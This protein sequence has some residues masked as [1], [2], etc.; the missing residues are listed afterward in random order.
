MKKVVD[1]LCISCT[2]VLGQEERDV[3]ASVTAVK[4]QR[5]CGN[6]L[7][8]LQTGLLSCKGYH[9]T[10]RKQP[11]VPAEKVKKLEEQIRQ[12]EAGDFGQDE[13]ALVFSAPF[14]GEQ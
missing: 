8:G 1:L 9:R 4:T 5:V 11:A 12:K 14:A 3:P 10:V 7:K 6:C 2:T 13:D